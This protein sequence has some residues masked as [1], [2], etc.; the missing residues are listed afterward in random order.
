[1]VVKSTYERNMEYRQRNSIPCFTS[2][3]VFAPFAFVQV[4]A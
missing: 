2:N 4:F 1:M 3:Q